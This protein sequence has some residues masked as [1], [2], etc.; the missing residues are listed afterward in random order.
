[1]S[2]GLG[3][4]WQGLSSL[5]RAALVAVLVGALLLPLACQRQARQAA[6]QARA[7]RE[8]ARAEAAAGRE[9]V[10]AVGAHAR[11]ASDSEALTRA[12]DKE[13][14]D[15][16]GADAMVDAGVHGAGLDGLCRRAAYRDDERCRL[17]G[18]GP[19]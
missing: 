15:A 17:R 2:G 19:R 16:T 11:A 7:E 9:A 13:I 8:G 6:A 4:W 3:R 12:N 18:A 5:L 14:R 1:M 10:E